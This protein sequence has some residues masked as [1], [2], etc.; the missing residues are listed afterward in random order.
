[1]LDPTAPLHE[2]LESLF[3]SAPELITLQNGLTVVFQPENTHPVISCQMWIKSGSCHEGD[4]LGSGLTHFIEHMLFKGSSKRGPGE[5][6]RE[7]QSFGGQIN[8]YTS[9]DR[10]VCLIE[11]PSEALA[12]SLDLL[13]DLTLNAALPKSEFEKEKQVIEREIDMTLDDPDRCLARSLFATA[14]R[15]HPFR[16]PVIG[17]PQRF[18]E[19]EHE[20]LSELYAAR[21]QP[22]N[23]VLSVAGDF[24]RGN[25]LRALES[26]FGSI[27]GKPCK[28]VHIPEEPKQLALREIR[29][30][31]DYQIARGLMGFKIPSLRDPDSAGLDLL[32]AILGSGHSA[33]LRQK[34]R[35]DL[36]F[37][38][39]ISASAWNPAEPGLFVI[40][41]QTDNEKARR[42]EEAILET[43]KVFTENLFSE[44]EIE[45]A[46]RFALVSEIQTRQTCSGLASR[47][48]LLQAV[49]GDLNYPKRYFEK[50]S[51]FTPARLRDIARTTFCAEK[52]TLGS[53]LSS[54]QKP[55]HRPRPT[56]NP[57]GDFTEEKLDNGARLIWQ[58][59][60]RLPRTFMRFAGLGGPLF[61]DPG[62]EGGTALL[63]TLL[64]RDT[65][66]QTAAQIAQSLETAGG[67]LQES[68]GNNSYSLAMEVLPDQALA[69]LQ[70]LNDGIFEPAFKFATV[71][72]EQSAQ[73]AALREMQDDVLD[74]GRLHLRKTFFGDHPFAHDP[75][76][77]TESVEK[78]DASHMRSLH[79]RL[80]VAQNSVLVLTGD[81]DPDTLL[82]EAEELLSQLPDWQFRSRP[83]PFANPAATGHEH[84][85]LDREQTVVF[86]AFPD[87]GFKAEDDLVADIIDEI[88]SDMSGPLFRTVREEQS[89]AYFVGASRIPGPD[90]GT[91]YLYAGT[92]P[93][94]VQAVYNAFAT[95]L[96]RLREG[97]VTSE[98]LMG[99]ITRLKVHNRFSLQ[100][101]ATRAARVAL[102]SLYGKPIM[103]W[104]DYED[105]ID[106]VSAE[107]VSQFCS[108]YLDTDH[109]VLLSVGPKATS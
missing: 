61:E 35:E 85:E 3:A 100:S 13:A 5:I 17:L 88:L 6:A 23:M 73:L 9:F 109:Q 43:C 95:E 44:E 16:Y 67:F 24:G 36:N 34:L 102:N 47:L 93:D 42:A 66:Y 83:L 25:L 37:V 69:G 90:F 30:F 71:G 92:H 80:L 89:L 29:N 39:H 84:I 7:V 21:F 10:T 77:T 19:V 12:L 81:F 79:K 50:L 72:R 18:A 97:K 70:I 96:Q 41:Y 31:G 87:C 40:Q 11:G 62:Y 59:D 53:L 107:N 1:M 94:S 65:K 63:S 75:L 54:E 52:L 105:R 103:D 51:G 74:Q 15:E 82:P 57:L 48:G 55:K 49:V 28:P 99:A 20:H 78:L 33:R 4:H 76:G 2:S 108:K 106:R 60:R 45:K 98:E 68:S 86:Q 8:G 56:A 38:H 101:P 58:T 104:L 91:F 26:T 14:Y 64:T 32:G 22:S 46:K 27:P